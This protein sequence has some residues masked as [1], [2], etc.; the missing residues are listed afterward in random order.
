MNSCRG[1][2]R[3]NLVV[4]GTISEIRR[5]MRDSIRRFRTGE[6]GTAPTPDELEAILDHVDTLERDLAGPRREGEDV[7][8][9]N[10]RHV[11]AAAR[12]NGAFHVRVRVDSLADL[13]RRLRTE[14]PV[15]E[16][17]DER[18]YG[19]RHGKKEIREADDE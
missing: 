15:G 11:I 10:L 17:S 9:A 6:G 8:L 4:R 12:A 3:S 18:Y 2:R 14:A 5:K 7:K 1:S 16:V 19:T 13:Y